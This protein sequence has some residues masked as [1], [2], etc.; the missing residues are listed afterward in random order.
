LNKKK[1]GESYWEL[2][3]ISPILNAKGE[4]T[5]FL[6]VKED[7][8]KRKK[9]EEEILQKNHQLSL[10]SDHR[11]IYVKKSVAIS[12]GKFMMSWASN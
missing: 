11:K 12:Q 2:A 4:I 7:I 8:T 1:N 5:N 6:A 9:A 3:L 10:L